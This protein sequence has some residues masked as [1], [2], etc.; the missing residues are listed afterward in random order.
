MTSSEKI[1]TELK[2]LFRWKDIEVKI[3][4][5]SANGDAI[6]GKA[7]A[8]HDARAV[9]DRLDSVLGFDNWREEHEPYCLGSMIGDK[10]TLTIQFLDAESGDWK[11]VVREEVSDASDIE[12][13][14]G[15]VS[16]SL[17]RAFAALANRSLYEIELGWHPAEKAG[18]STR[19]TAEAMKNIQKLYESQ[20]AALA[21]SGAYPSADGGGE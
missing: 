2:R 16:G 13:I 1:Y 18:R 7:V 8:Y 14:K 6:R 12:P 17:K 3:Q 10:C 21:A 9:R 20:I 4:S 5:T 19:F 15:A 11:S